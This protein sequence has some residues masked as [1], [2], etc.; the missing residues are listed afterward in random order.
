MPSVNENELE[1]LEFWKKDKT[2]QKSLKGKK[3]EYIFYDGPPFATGLPHYGHLLAST[4]KDAIPRFWTMKGYNVRRV[5]GWDCHGLPIES[6]AEKNLGFKDKKQIEEMGVK[7]FCDYCESMVLKYTGEW[8]KTIERVGRWVEFDN[9]YKTMDN[10]YMESIWWA[11]KEIWKKGL[12]YEGRKVL[13]Y[14]PHCETPLSNAEIAMD[15]SYKDVIEDSVFVK[16]K[17]DKNR[18]FL[19]WTTTPWTLIGNIALAVKTDADYVIVKENENEYILAK[20][21][22]NELKGEHKIIK[23]MKGKD[24]EGMKYEPLYNV[25]HDK[26]G[27]Y[28]ISDKEGVNTEDGS[29]IVHLAIYG[30]F[31]YAMI[32]K[33]NLPFIEHIGSDGKLKDGPEE[34]KGEWFKK[35]DAKVIRDLENRGLMYKSNRTTHSYPFCYRCDTPLFYSPLPSWFINIQKVK[36]KMLNENDKIN[37]YPSH[38]KDGRFKNIVE[39]APDWNISRNRY[40]ASV[41]PIWKCSCG[42][43]KVIGSI[44]EL[45]KNAISLPKKIDLHK[46]SMDSV[47]LKCTCGEK[48][49][50]VPEVLDCWFESGAMPFAQVNYPF[51]NKKWFENNF[52]GDFVAE[53]IAQTRT[54]F[55]YMLAISVMLFEKAPF[56]NVVTTGTILAFDG[57]KMSKSKG[58]FPDPI[59]IIEKYGADALRFYLLSGNLMNAEDIRFSEKNV[60]DVYKKI[61]LILN[62]VKQFYSMS[63]VKRKDK[64]N[65]KNVLDKWII[66]RLN[67]TG[68]IVSENLEKYNTPE[69]CKYISSFISDLS[70]WYVRRS[71]ERFTSDNGEAKSVLYEVLINFSKIISPFMPFISESIFQEVS[72]GSKSVHL[73]DWPEF[74]KKKIDEE[75]L[76]MMNLTRDV[77][78]LTLKERD[79]AKIPVRQVLGSLE[80]EGAELSDEYK[81][82]IMEEVNI[83]K[84]IFKKGKVM[85]VLLDTKITPELESEG[86]AREFVRNIQ[87]QRKNLGLKK[88][89]KIILKIKC[90]ENMQRIIK[91]NLEVISEKIN[92][93]K[94]IFIDDISDKK[95][96]VFTIKDE[97]I[98]SLVCNL[99]GKAK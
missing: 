42:E 38:L 52:P 41:I 57:E 72:G 44:D 49:K 89:E 53:Y 27:Y 98:T 17:T 91:E 95:V 32:Q 22:V 69:A 34:W 43:M 47:Y 76:K 93:V 7:E 50:R 78:S 16:F 60:E 1:I 68:L 67:E 14:C 80:I 81:S 56:K 5:W 92:S 73:Q 13:L 19:A 86:M 85:K 10:S 3:K 45:K 31:D 55:Y 6:L 12:I 8:K 30:E 18:F 26:K 15:N 11:F 4:I 2:F 66:S 51:E 87:S 46:G 48:M 20:E 23:N 65:S 64:S 77:V 33:H 62:N 24:L 71:R 84:V 70:N 29:G 79:S 75:V 99:E 82:L 25:K 35:L 40:W 28:V 54:W 88:E 74:S 83:K 94:I 36:K 59:N 37:W 61:I 39:N 90:S 9:S 63:D 96:F 58:N 97:N 21:K